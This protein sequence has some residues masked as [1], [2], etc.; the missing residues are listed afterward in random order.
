V[1]YSLFDQSDTLFSEA[2]GFIIFASLCHLQVRPTTGS[3][4]SW[5]LLT[6]APSYSALFFQ[7]AQKVSVFGAAPG[8]SAAMGVRE[9]HAREGTAKDRSALSV[10]DHPKGTSPGMSQEHDGRQALALGAAQAA[11]PDA[12]LCAGRVTG[13]HTVVHSPEWVAH[14]GASTRYATVPDETLERNSFV[15]TGFVLD[16]QLLW[17]RR[18]LSAL[19]VGLATRPVPVPTPLWMAVGRALTVMPRGRVLRGRA[20]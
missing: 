7:E 19:S 12:C 1:L 3:K 13:W 6:T 10:G 11:C 16:A 14:G 2:H 5:P 4:D 18:V 15:W 20:G 8:P 9:D 17:R